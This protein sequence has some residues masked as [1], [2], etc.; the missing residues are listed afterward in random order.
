MELV[1]PGADYL[2]SYVEALKKGWSPNNLRPEAAGE[3]LDE[4]ARDSSAYLARQVDL[5]GNGPPVILPD[6]TTAQRLPGY[7]RWMWD[8][9]FCGSIGFRWQPGS[10]ELPPHVLGHIGYAVVPWK[11]GRGYATRALALLL[12]ELGHTGLEYVE[13]TTEPDN[14]ASQRV[15]VA[16][17]GQLVERFTKPAAYG[18]D[19]GLRF[20]IY[21]SK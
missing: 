2:A 21:L 16:N 3:E 7:R 9:E 6:G 4:I 18:G 15:I 10:N 17:G 13:L 12:P 19:P 14:I 1:W 5:E 20:R 8:G 11:Q